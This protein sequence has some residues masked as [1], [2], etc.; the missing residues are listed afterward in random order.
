MRRSDGF[1]KN[2][3]PV[4]AGI[5]V[6]VVGIGVVFP[7]V[8]TFLWARLWLFAE[9]RHP[10]LHVVPE[11]GISIDPVSLSGRELL[12]IPSRNLEVFFEVEEGVQVREFGKDGAFMQF[13]SGKGVLVKPAENLWKAL[14]KMEGATENRMAA[15]LSDSDLESPYQ[16][17]RKTLSLTPAV[18]SPFAPMLELDGLIALLITK[19]LLFEDV[20]E[21]IQPVRLER[22][23]GFLYRYKERISRVDLF[24]KADHYEISTYGMGEKALRE[25]L[26]RVRFEREG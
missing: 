3:L 24:Y 21:S 17:R 16:L 20:P 18:L 22:G 11:P 15:V 2:H 19:K 4:L 14:S 5:L 7:Q 9:W 8:P 10:E 25:M 1:L 6:L 13:P 12:R 26:A 23:G